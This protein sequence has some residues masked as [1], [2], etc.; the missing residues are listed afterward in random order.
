MPRPLLALLVASAVVLAAPAPAGAAR[1]LVTGFYDSSLTEPQWADRAVE[2][3]A[4]AVRVHAAWSQIAPLVRPEGFDASDPAAPGYDWDALDAG[5]RPLAERGLSIVLS[6]DRAPRWAEGTGRRSSAPAGSWKP[7]PAEVG[8]FG[9]ALARRYGGSFPDPAAPGQTLPAVRAFQLWNEPNLAL[10][11]GPQWSGRRPFAPGHYRRMLARFRAGV[12]AHA[13]RA[14]VATGGTSPYGDPGAGEARMQ[15]LRFLRELL[16]LRKDLRRRSCSASVRADVI[17]HHPYSV[18]RPRRRALNRDDAS[19]PDLGKIARAIRAARR[20][21]TLRSA[22]RLWV[23]EVSYDSRPPDP[24]GVPLA[25]HARWAQETLYLLWKQGAG[26]VIWLTIRDGEPHPDYASSIQAGPFFRDGR[27]KPAARAFRFPFV[28]ERVSRSRVR[29][30]G[31]SPVAG[32]LVV[33]RR[34]GSRWV[35]VLSLRAGA[36]STFLR[37]V[38]QRGRATLRARVAGETSLSW[39][40]R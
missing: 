8:R 2:V 7:D 14:L 11:L 26:T 22:P 23:T 25:T 34:S 19:I 17:A 18:G 21:R 3:G 30:W 9:E 16:C 1:P 10:Y 29:V 35:R 37:S 39:S 31:R 24:D 40:Q 28:A 13:P 15:P 33:E 32:R 4:G 36:R 38:R 6:F 20:L 12:K 5:L 27:A